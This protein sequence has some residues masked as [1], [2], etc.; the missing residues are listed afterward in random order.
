MHRLLNIQLKN[1]LHPPNYLSKREQNRIFL[2]P[3]LFE[4]TN[5]IEYNKEAKRKNSIRMRLF[6]FVDN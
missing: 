3:N 2:F 1:N 6:F 5:S 4:N